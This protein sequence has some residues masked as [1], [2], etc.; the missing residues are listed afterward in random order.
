MTFLQGTVQVPVPVE[1]IVDVP[2]IVTRKRQVRN[3]RFVTPIRCK[4][5][6]IETKFHKIW[7]EFTFCDVTKVP[8]IIEKVVEVPR[9]KI[10]EQIIENIV[11]EK[12][13]A[14]LQTH[15]HHSRSQNVLAS[16]TTYIK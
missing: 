8:R 6:T 9:T 12:M 2:Q 1:K 13:I 7:C 14:N 4:N 5:Y 11:D 15:S 3:L 10:V 16:K